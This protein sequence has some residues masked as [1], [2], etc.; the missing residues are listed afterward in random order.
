MRQARVKQQPGEMGYYHCIS[1]VVDRQFVLGEEEKEQ[2][3]RLMRGYEEFCGLKVI[4]YCM[5]SN[6]F[7]ILVQVPQRPER[8]HLPSDSQLV[9]LL[10]KARDCYGSA[11]LEK[12]LKALRESRAAGAA[13]AA[14]ALRERF[15]C[16]MWDVSWFMRLLKGRFSQWFNKRHQRKGTLWEDRFKSILVEGAGQALCTMAIYIDLNAVRGALVAEPG[17]YRWCGYGEAL[18]GVRAARQGLA[19][20]VNALGSGYG[21]GGHGRE[22][23]AAVATGVAE[24]VPQQRVMAEYR[25]ELF[26]RGQ[27]RLD[28]EG[29]VVRA[30]ISA[31]RIQEVL[32]KKGRLERWEALRC[33]V[34]Y[35]SDGMILG[36][37]PFVERF[38]AINR[39]RFG[40]TRKNGA[41]A[42][43]YLN[44]PQLYTMRDLQ[45]AP[46]G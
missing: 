9:A 20:V 1:R 36:S 27:A 14:E 19:V 45:K 2:L 41:R 16:R 3:V 37:R 22:E 28:Q 17:A 42:M 10:A 4:T 6:H 29:K 15:F 23:A 40:P 35:F 5:M 43:R 31:R 34:R 13:A 32:H 21:H 7:H 26:G 12:E 18:A 38:F 25:L 24:V 33:R 30:G 39:W 11:T 8:E 44:L 46:I